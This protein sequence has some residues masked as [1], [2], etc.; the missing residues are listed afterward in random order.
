MKEVRPIEDFELFQCFQQGDAVAFDII[1]DRYWGRLYR[2]AYKMVQ[3]KAEAED[4][5]QD[6]FIK[7]WENRNNIENTN[8]AGY[9]S[10]ISYHFLLKSLQKKQRNVQASANLAIVVDNTVSDADHHLYLTELQ[11]MVADC[12][13][14]LPPQCKTI[15]HLSREQH[16]SVKEIATNLGLSAKTVENQITIALKRLRNIVTHL[17]FLLLLFM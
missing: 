9:L 17:L 12:I 13:E 4:I 2:L 7:F 8:I 10:T 14:A 5:V 15:Y 16:L 1:Y 11:E 6:T 3:N